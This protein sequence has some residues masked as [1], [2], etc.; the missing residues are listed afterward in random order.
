[1]MILHAVLNHS[2]ISPKGIYDVGTI[3]AFYALVASARR[4]KT[5]SLTSTNAFTMS[6]VDFCTQSSNELFPAPH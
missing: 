4:D 2:S 6:P 3:Y 5:V 1:M